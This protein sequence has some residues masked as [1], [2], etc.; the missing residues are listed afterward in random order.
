MTTNGKYGRRIATGIAAAL[1]ATVSGG[2][3]AQ[4]PRGGLG[5]TADEQK[6]GITQEM[7]NRRAAEALSAI[8]IADPIELKRF[9]AANF[10]PG[11]PGPAEA[12]MIN[13]IGG[14]RADSGGLSFVSAAAAG[15]DMVAVK[16]DNA[17]TG[18]RDT[19][20]LRL[21]P[22]AP[23]R[24]RG[25]GM[26]LPE[27]PAR[28]Q[29][30]LP[31]SALAGAAKQL[32]SRLASVDGFSGAYLLARGD[33]VLFAGAYGDA[34]KDFGVPNTLDTRFNLGSMN[35]MFTA[36]AIAQLVEAGKLSFEDPVSKFLP[37]LLAPGAAEKI[38]IKHLLTHSG[39]LGS[40]FT[41]KFM[42]ASRANF[43]ST[44]DYLE[45]I[46]GAAPAFEPGTRTEY[47]N[48]GFLVLGRIVEIASGQDYHDYVREK[49]YLPAGMT[50]T[51]E[52]E[53]DK[54]NRNLAVGYERSFG[55]SGKSYR[56]NI[57]EHV[58]R[59]GP[60]G[61]GYSTA[62][63]LH[64]FAI[65]LLSGRLISRDMMKTLTTPKPERGAKQYGYGFA[66][67]PDGRIVGHSGGFPG[68]SSNLDILPATGQVM[69][70]LSNYG[71]GGM[72]LLP[73]RDLVLAQEAPAP[74][75]IA[76]QRPSS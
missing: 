28:L 44:A 2:T 61:G 4:H 51:G 1:L 69:V 17:V 49:I 6:P 31:D 70:I 11:L 40:H 57:F 60:A 26:Y 42:N 23:H 10:A 67:S 21:E 24:I 66:I 53:L 48:G 59:G 37:D 18:W 50:S 62:G 72:K 47:S 13:M 36:V 22:E 7:A 16:V 65:A 15:P 29:G 3:V 54:V 8:R 38:R 71:H 14:L 75:A 52:F 73:L 64:R 39:G 46:R 27:P 19:V 25:V 56:N 55:E 12:R 63:D 35:K 74:A 5:M 32:A 9:I 30:S 58:I 45:L 41:D 68:I 20:M 34:N 76:S 43:R 33:K